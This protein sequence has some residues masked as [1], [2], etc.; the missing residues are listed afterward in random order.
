[1]PTSTRKSTPR[2]RNAAISADSTPQ[3]R[4]IWTAVRLHTMNLPTWWPPAFGNKNL[5]VAEKRDNVVLAIQLR[6]WI[7][8][9]EHWDHPMLQILLLYQIIEVDSSAG[10][11]REPKYKT[12]SAEPTPLK[13]AKLLRDLCSHQGR[14]GNKELIN[15]CKRRQ[16]PEDRFPTPADESAWSTIK[17][18]I[19]VILQLAHTLIKQKLMR[20]S[21]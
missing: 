9:W 8:A 6:L 3:L 19:P 13:E 12:R 17:G 14:I 11:A 1:M 16:L 4:L 2:P 7:L 15:Y 5:T 20:N 10:P 18:R 21:S